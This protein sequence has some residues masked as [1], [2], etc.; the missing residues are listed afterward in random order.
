MEHSPR[1]S[2]TA[3]SLSVWSGKP[4]TLRCPAPLRTGRARFRAPGSSKPHGLVG[5]QRCRTAAVAAADVNETGFVLV[6]LG[7][8]GGDDLGEPL[9]GARQSLL[10]LARV[11]WAVVVGQEQGPAD[12]AAT[13]LGFEKPRAG[14]V[15]RR[16][17]FA[18]PLAPVVGKGG[19]VG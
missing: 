12:R 2:P 10:P 18:P 3:T 8:V 16:A 15:D 7:G 9:A 13:I 1:T 14:L 6:G 4:D 19:V 11:L 5:G 17:R